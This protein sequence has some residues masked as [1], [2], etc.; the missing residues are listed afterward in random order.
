M[1]VVCGSREA[2]TSF[3]ATM[4]SQLLPEIVGRQLVGLVGELVCAWN[5]LTADT[6]LVVSPSLL[7]QDRKLPFPLV[8]DRKRI[9]GE[10]PKPKIIY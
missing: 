1:K 2:V 10:T 4:K 8:C 9:N 5:S 7:W 3:G 6:F